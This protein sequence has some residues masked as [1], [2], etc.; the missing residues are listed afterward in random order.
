MKQIIFV[1]DI[2]N[3]VVDN[4]H[5]DEYYKLKTATPLSINESDDNDYILELLCTNKNDDKFIINTIFQSDEDEAEL[6][7][8]YLSCLPMFEQSQ[9]VSN[10]LAHKIIE[11][12]LTTYVTDFV[13]EY[14]EDELSSDIKT[15][16][17]K[18]Y[19]KD[20]GSS[21]TFEVNVELY[22]AIRY[23]L[24]YILTKDYNLRTLA[25]ACLV[26]ANNENTEL[27]ITM[28]KS[29]DNIVNLAKIDKSGNVAI[30]VQ[31]TDESD[32]KYL[33]LTSFNLGYNLSRRKTKGCT[34]K[35]IENY[36]LSDKDQFM[37]IYSF[38]TSFKKN[39]KSYIVIRAVN[40]DKEYKLFM[41][42]RINQEKIIELINDR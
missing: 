3:E 34:V 30:V 20:S 19:E 27:K 17:F 42:N 21:C 18:A 14:K 16:Y 32:E 7:K 37:N 12:S 8:E 22:S 40:N 38:D 39:G 2:E 6:D 29:I 4:S 23:Y 10:V 28:I 35:R 26:G 25:S 11:N 15:F 13:F 9:F 1:D 36:F 33:L 24:S 31:C 5:D 41:L